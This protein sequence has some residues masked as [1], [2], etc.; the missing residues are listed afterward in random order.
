[1]AA[2]TDRNAAGFLVCVNT[3]SPNRSAATQRC[4]EES[5]VST[6]R[7]EDP[8]RRTLDAGYAGRTPRFAYFT[9]LRRGTAA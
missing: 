1:M 9:R 3:S 8:T 6:G 5:C 4:A 2:N 7:A